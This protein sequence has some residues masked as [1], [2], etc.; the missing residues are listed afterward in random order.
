MSDFFWDALIGIPGLLLTWWLLKGKWRQ[1]EERHADFQKLARELGLQ[2]NAT[3][4]GLREGQAEPSE[5]ADLRSTA[6][7][8]AG[9][10]ALAA[11]PLSS[12]FTIDGS[13]D[14]V[15]VSITLHQRSGDGAGAHTTRLSARIDSP[16]GLA[17]VSICRS[18]AVDRLLDR[19]TGG[20]DIELGDAA[21]DDAVRVRGT[22]A[23]A[24]RAWL[25]RADMRQHVQR[26]L[27]DFDTG[28]IDAH[29]VHLDLAGAV[30]DSARVRTAMQATV[31]LSKALS[32]A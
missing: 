6:V 12:Q 17:N 5:Q 23:E 9:L 22:P 29:G 24:V 18:Y 28:S 13:F 16:P 2:F 31:A 32:R 20:Q 8:R 19:A 21:F 15:P 7:G 3:H 4:M 25:S 26:Y 14:A 10:Q 1:R 30:S 11:M 27:T